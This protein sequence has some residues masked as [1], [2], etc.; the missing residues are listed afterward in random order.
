MIL[1]N[2]YEDI[3]AARIRNMALNQLMMNIQK[4]KLTYPFNERPSGRSYLELVKS[5]KSSLN[6]N[7]SLDGELAG[8]VLIFITYIIIY[9]L[10]LK[11]SQE[12]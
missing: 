9:R 5:L 10:A 11:V 2:S 6:Q 3:T 12:T 7:T 1:R 4:N 8:D